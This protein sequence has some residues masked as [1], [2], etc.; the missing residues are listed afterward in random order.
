[1]TC[2]YVKTPINTEESKAIT[3]RISKNGV[4]V[5]CPPQKQAGGLKG[6]CGHW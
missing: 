6:N 5:K 1:M 3:E 2:L 4:R